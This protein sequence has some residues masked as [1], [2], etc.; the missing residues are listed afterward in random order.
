MSEIPFAL[1]LGAGVLAAVNPC[2][3]AMLPA[4]L[5]LL[6]VGEDSPGGAVAVGRALT[7]TAAMTA[8]FAAVFGLFGLAIAPVAGQIQQHLP[9]FTVVLGLVLAATGAWLISG[10]ELPVLV[11]KLRRGPVVRRRVMS[12]ALYGAAYAI[13]SV[14]CTIGPFLAI[15]VSAFR[16]ESTITGIALFAAYAA[17]MGLIVG[18]AALAVALGQAGVVGW[19]RRSGR[20]ASRLGGGLLLVAGSYV[21]YY[22]WYELR[23]F[24]GTTTMDPVVNA[25]GRLQTWLATGVDR[26]GVTT[27]AVLFAVLLVLSL[28][29]IRSRSRKPRRMWR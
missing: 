28:I 3:F 19:L 5:T 2:G 1:A 17:G 21:A 9:W 25:A 24:R 11:P 13:A 29:L 27:L 10:R 16:T 14:G 22:G 20:L 4:Y 26:L 12:M 6:L 18:A 8:G 23:V 15:V 7:A